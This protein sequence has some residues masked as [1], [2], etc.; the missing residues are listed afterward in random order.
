MCFVF[1]LFREERTGGRC[2]YWC[3][4][5]SPSVVADRLEWT[6]FED[7]FSLLRPF[8]PIASFQYAVPEW[9]KR[10]LAANPFVQTR[11]WRFL[12]LSPHSIL[13]PCIVVLSRLD[14]TNVELTSKTST[15]SVRRIFCAFM[16][17]RLRQPKAFRTIYPK[18]ATVERRLGVAC[19]WN[20]F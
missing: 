12:P 11:N 2:R 16:K 5:S 13:L 7:G 9:T 3:T 17:F 4:S 10:A 14:R 8:E 15:V 19:G 6:M 18:E 1:W 20:P